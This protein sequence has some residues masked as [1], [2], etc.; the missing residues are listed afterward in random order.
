MIKKIF[1]WT[2]ALVLLIILCVS[3]VVPFRQNLTYEAPYPEL[4]ATTDTAVIARGRELVLGAAHCVDC[5]STKRA[6]PLTGIDA[7]PV[8]SGGVKFALPV[9]EVYSKNITP[10][11][12]KKSQGFFVMEFMLMAPQFMISCPFTICR[13]R[14]WSVSFRTCGV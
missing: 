6:D 4:N 2:G 3:A 1:K 14:T 7:E 11:S 5:H 10:D 12:T 13:M 8:L 9:G